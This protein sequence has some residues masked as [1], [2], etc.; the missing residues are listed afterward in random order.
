MDNDFL[1]FNALTRGIED[2]Q[3]FDQPGRFKVGAAGARE[4]GIP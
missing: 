2:V 4:L 1:V 3:P